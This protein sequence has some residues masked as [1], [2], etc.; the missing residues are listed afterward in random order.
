MNALT[1]PQIPGTK[2]RDPLIDLLCGYIPRSV[3]IGNRN[4][5]V[6]ADRVRLHIKIIH[7]LAVCCARTRPHFTRHPAHMARLCIFGIGIVIQPV[8]AQHIGIIG[9][10]L[11]HVQKHAA[12]VVRFHKLARTDIGIAY[13][14]EQIANCWRGFAAVIAIGTI[15]QLIAVIAVV[16]I[17]QL[18]IIIPV[19]HLIPYTAS[20][21]ASIVSTTSIFGINRD[22]R[23]TSRT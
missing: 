21:Q 9:R 23:A 4:A 13:P 16:Y 1:G 6:A 20:E 17:E 7:G 8:L 10:R 14:I 19:I 12:F 5:V 2:G 3:G 11:I 15:P 22:M 18:F